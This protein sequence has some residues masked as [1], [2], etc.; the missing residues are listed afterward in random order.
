[1]AQYFDAHN[2]PPISDE[3]G[4]PRRRQ[5]RSYTSRETYNRRELTER[6]GD[7]PDIDERLDSLRYDTKD[8]FDAARRP[9]TSRPERHFSRDD[10][11]A[12]DDVFAEKRRR[13][14]VRLKG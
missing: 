5:P 12:G 3:T 9:Y 7:Y 11:T 13:R 10:G 1:M 2:K 6:M 4:S 14:E 8:R